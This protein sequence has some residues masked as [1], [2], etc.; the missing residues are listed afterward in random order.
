MSER[1]TEVIERIAQTARNTP[2]NMMNIN[3][4]NNRIN[5]NN[6]VYERSETLDNNISNDE[7]RNSSTIIGQRKI[8]SYRPVHQKYLMKV[9]EQIYDSRELRR[10]INRN[11]SIPHTRLPISTQQRR[12]LQNHLNR[13]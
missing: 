6:A 13:N 2:P 8:S 4:N 5:N 7:F 10:W 11:P 1:M 12:S 9:D 3:N